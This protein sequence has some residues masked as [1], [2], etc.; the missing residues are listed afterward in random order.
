MK[1][2]GECYTYVYLSEQVTKSKS[3][4]V[5]GMHMQHIIVSIKGEK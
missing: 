2:F 3:Y 1:L 5:I 4:V